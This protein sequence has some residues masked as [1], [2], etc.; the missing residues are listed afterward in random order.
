MANAF[1]RIASRS[2]FSYTDGMPKIQPKPTRTANGGWQLRIMVP[3]ALREAGFLEGQHEFRRTRGPCSKAQAD[4]WAAGL[5]AGFL[6]ARERFEAV[7]SGAF[8]PEVIEDYQA[9]LRKGAYD[10]QAEE[11]AGALFDEL[12]DRRLKAAGVTPAANISSPWKAIATQPGGQAVLKDLDR[13][14]GN[15]VDFDSQ[16]ERWLTLLKVSEKTARMYGHDVR[17]FLDEVGPEAAFSRTT[18]VAWHQGQLLGGSITAKTI[19]RKLTAL[20]GFHKHLLEVG[21]LDPDGPMGR[22]FEGLV[23]KN[24]RAA[25][26]STDTRAWADAEVTALYT[27]AKTKKNSQLA[28]VIALAMFT[29]A[30]IEALFKLRAQDIDLQAQTMVLGASGDKTEAGRDRLVPIAQA[31]LPIIERLMDGVDEPRDFLLKVS[32]RNPSR[33]HGAVKAFYRLKTELFPGSQR[34]ATFHSFRQ[35]LITKLA[36]EV[37]A[38]EHFIADLV[39]HENRKAMTMGLYRGRSRPEEIRPYLDQLHYQGWSLH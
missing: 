36:N 29:G 38:P 10:W 30:R 12:V 13:L 9:L 21:L 15:T 7:Q 2:S 37:Q 31:I 27:A 6:Q 25:K 22:P 8:T 3:K 4:A 23:T 14:S 11:A 17:A 34:E 1:S 39:G 28:D 5:Y 19:D 35:S 33:S 18:V 26:A 20:K 24:K 32:H 16:L